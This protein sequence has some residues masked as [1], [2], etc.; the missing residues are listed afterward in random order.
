MPVLDVSKIGADLYFLLIFPVFSFHFFSCFSLLGFSPASD[1]IFY[2][3][4]LFC[5]GFR[6]GG[7]ANCFELALR[8]V[9]MSE[10]VF[11]LLLEF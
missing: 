5:L 3:D 1:R 7:F 9:A 8:F 2:T 4:F 10:C 11:L 6:F